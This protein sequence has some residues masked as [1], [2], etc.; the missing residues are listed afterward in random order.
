MNEGINPVDFDGL[1]LSV[2]TDQSKAINTDKTP[3]VIIASSGMCEAGRIRHHLKHNLWRKESLVLFVGYQSAGT[4]GRKIFDG[5]KT[6][7][8]FNEQITVA[9]ESTYLAGISGHADK[10]GLK[11][12]IGSFEE[13][14][15]IVFLNHGDHDPMESFGA[16]LRADGYRVEMPYSG[17]SF[18]LL[19][20]EPVEITEGLRLKPK[21][22]NASEAQKQTALANAEKELSSAIESLNR[23]LAGRTL[24]ASQLCALADAVNAAA[25]EYD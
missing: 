3:K 9:C 15:A 21:K 18:D 11:K 19:T 20:G 6:V 24:S 22:K 10:N 7:K 25:A 16:E 17:T 14:P 1:R 23:L 2:T 13:K 5:A 4:L 12:W 8:L